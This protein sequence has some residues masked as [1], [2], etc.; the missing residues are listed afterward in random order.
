MSLEFGR[1]GLGRSVS[2]VS[3]LAHYPFAW[4][5]VGTSSWL[6]SSFWL[7]RMLQRGVFET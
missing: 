5:L 3:H 2:K 6:V 1:G 7:R 4:I